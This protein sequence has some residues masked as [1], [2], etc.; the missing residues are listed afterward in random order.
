MPKHRKQA[1]KAYFQRASSGQVNWLLQRHNFDQMSGGDPMPTT[2]S[3]GFLHQSSPISGA[4]FFRW[5]EQ[6]E[7]QS[8]E[9]S[10][11]N[12]SEVLIQEAAS[13]QANGA[14]P[15]EPA[16]SLK[17][18]RKRGRRRRRQGD[19]G[20]DA[21]TRALRQKAAQIV[22]AIAR[23]DPNTER[24]VLKA[25]DLTDAQEGVIRPIV[26]RMLLSLTDPEYPLDMT[27]LG[28]TLDAADHGDC[29]QERTITIGSANVSSWRR[30]ILDWVTAHTAEVWCI[31]ETHLTAEGASLLRQQSAARGYA[32]FGGE[33]SAPNP[34]PKGGHGILTATN[35]HGQLLGAFN[36]DGC[37]YTGVKIPACKGDLAIFSLYLLNGAGLQ[38]ATNAE[39]L[40]ALATELTG[41]PNC[42]VLGDWNNTPDE[43]NATRW[44]E[45]VKG[46]TIAAGEPTLTTGRE[47]DYGLI[48]SHLQGLASIQIDWEVPFK[49]HGAAL[50]KVRL[51]Y[52]E[53]PLPQ[54][55]IPAAKV[56]DPEQEPDAFVQPQLGEVAGVLLTQD[57]ATQDFADLTGQAEL[58]VYGRQ[59]N[60]GAHLPTV[61]KT[62]A[63]VKGEPRSRGPEANRLQVLAAWAKANEAGQLH[64]HLRKKLQEAVDQMK[65][66]GQM[67]EPCDGSTTYAQMPVWRMRLQNRLG[68]GRP[69]PINGGW[70]REPRKV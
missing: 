18:R 15:K 47:L 37:G 24:L 40:A 1:R 20:T 53:I 12:S 54:H 25:Y 9:N 5:Q 67:E 60:R 38:H 52:G 50:V 28:A 51:H 10:A 70:R 55:S 23:G 34:R 31:Q 3:Q 42:L 48:S 56:R 59:Q 13:T 8:D 14:T 4:K 66:D 30:E 19:P 45:M 11:L 21:R 41:H 58:H 62:L 69:C 61:R 36:I 46:T 32:A 22:S 2:H 49:P 64:P 63:R 39:I 26:E 7:E 43:L 33:G 68:K 17:T 29:P 57:P 6:G 44:P 35:Q 16:L 27:A 65:A